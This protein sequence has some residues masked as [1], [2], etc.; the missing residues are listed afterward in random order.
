MAS[1]RS[2]ACICF[3]SSVVLAEALQNSDARTRLGKI[4]E[5]QRSLRLDIFLP[6]TVKDECNARIQ[7]VISF[8]ANLIRDFERFL[9]KK[10]RSDRTQKVITIID[11]KYVEQFIMQEL[12]KF[13][14]N[15]SESEILR[16]IEAMIVS[17]L[18]EKINAGKTAYSKLM[19]DMMVEIVKYGN[20]I[21]DRFNLIMKKTLV[22]TENID[23]VLL[24]KLKKEPVFEK[25]VRKKPNDL[26]II[27]EVQAHQKKTK[28]WSILVTLDFNDML[29]NAQ[30][31]EEIAGIKCTDPLYLPQIIQTVKSQKIK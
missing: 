28:K 18:L 23:Q 20:L 4:D 13:K 1:P 5:Y 31:I 19:I 2:Y 16:R 10:K 15:S 24:E 3:D 9:R 6:T 14:R 27:C 8:V 26:Q 7:V 22:I 11:T 17:Y 25:T 12:K 21:R 30:K 29:Q